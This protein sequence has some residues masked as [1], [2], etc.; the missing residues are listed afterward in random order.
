MGLIGKAMAFKAGKAIFDRARRNRAT[1]RRP[2]ATASRAGARPATRR[3]GGRGLAGIARSLL[4][5]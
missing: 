5:R 1:T 4:G 2:A 3:T